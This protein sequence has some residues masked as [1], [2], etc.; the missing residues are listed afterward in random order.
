M[1]YVYMLRGKVDGTRYYAGK[2]F[3]L[4]AVS[5]IVGIA[6]KRSVFFLKDAGHRVLNTK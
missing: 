1:H 6:T 5:C 4:L 3:N 2:A